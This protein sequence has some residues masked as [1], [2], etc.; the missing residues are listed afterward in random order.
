MKK[1]DLIW[2]LDGVLEYLRMQE[3]G[4]LWVVQ[5]VVNANKIQAKSLATGYV[6][7]WFRVE[8]DTYEKG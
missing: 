5:R 3:H 8:F 7:V 4:N 1:G 2:V 6:F